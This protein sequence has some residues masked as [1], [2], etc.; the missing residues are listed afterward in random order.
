MKVVR[1]L[2][3]TIRSEVKNLKKI[4]RDPVLTAAIMF[5][6]L[7]LSIFIVVPLLTILQQSIYSNDGSISF[8]AYTRV[9][10]SS[11]NLKAL[12]NTLFL[13]AV[14]GILSTIAGFLFA[15]CFAYLKTAGKKIF[16]FIAILPMISPPFSVALSII[17]LFG[18]RG[19]ISNTLLGLRDSNIYGL[20]G[21]IIVQTLSF[22]PI[23]YLLLV[24]MFKSI[25]PAVE[26]A[27]RNLGASKWKTFKR[28][29]LPLV[30]PGIANAFL[31]VFIKSVADFA[32]PMAIGGNF[33]TLATQI[34]IQ[35]IGNYDMQGGAAVAVILLDISIILFIISKYWV[36]KKVYVTVTGKAAR[37]RTLIADR[38]VVWPVAGI[39]YAM[40]LVVILLYA[41][42]PIGSVIKLWGINYSLTLDHYRYAIS[43]GGKAIF[44]T[45]WLSLVA[46]PI[47]GILGMIIAY[48]VVRKNF[49]GKGFINFASLLSIAVPGT[50]VGIG[51]I[52]AFN[53]KP[54]V[55]TGTAAI[56]VIAFIIRSIP[57]GIRAGV[58]S[59]Q[60]IDPGIEEA[61]ANLGASSTQVFT[62]IT[63]PLIKSAFFSGLVYSFIRS[64]TS[65][66]AVIFL[67]T[68]KYN[69]LTVAIL[70]QVESG[71]F[72]VASAFSTILI[73]IVYVAIV[74]MN[75][76]LE[77]VGASD[78]K[79]ELT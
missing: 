2:N 4:V 79:I 44:D 15:Y 17:L 51:F 20:K 21:L 54:L 11:E 35:A 58:S 39:C 77:Y 47:T 70:D 75:K 14:V 27:A 24:G 46:T 53:T 65:I 6:I 69:L 38:S 50:V 45:T 32:N 25:D 19:L 68:A 67:I 48:L 76:V 62:K 61:A 49:I 57:V 59:L 78:K 8:T 72:G 63:L 9:F 73:C 5:V 12:G 42:I 18:S 29:T 22:F 36:E 31:L 56:L 55:L 40:S 16:N 13:A 43:V 10:S 30:T 64:M 3:Y 74:I 66:S 52:L 7:S 37:V 28:V 71:K 33:Q 34:Y 60:Q 26:E 1:Q 41:L 23:A